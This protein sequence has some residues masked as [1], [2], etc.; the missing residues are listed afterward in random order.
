MSS[1]IGHFGTTCCLGCDVT[2]EREILKGL[3]MG[4]GSYYCDG[5]TMQIKNVDVIRICAKMLCCTHNVC[6]CMAELFVL[7][8]LCHHVFFTK[9]LE[10]VICCV[11]VLEASLFCCLDNQRAF[12]TKMD[13]GWSRER[14]RGRE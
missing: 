14:G 5:S 13:G 9:A 7:V 6:L 12:H 8:S 10:K 3:G 11:D 2:I 4:R 1:L